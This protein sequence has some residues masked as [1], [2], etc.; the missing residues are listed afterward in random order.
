MSSEQ[1]GG[2]HILQ[3]PDGNVEIRFELKTGLVL[4]VPSENC[5]FYSI[6]Y[7]GREVIEES[8]LGLRFSAAG[9]LSNCFEVVNVRTS[10]HDDEWEPV[11]GERAVIPDC[12]RE[13]TVE[14]RETIPPGRKL[15][16]TFRA[17]NEGAALRYTIP[18]Q[19]GLAELCIIDELTH[20]TFPEGA[21]GYAEYH[22]EGEYEKVPVDEIKPNCEW[23]LTVQCPNGVCL[24][25]TEAN[26]YD[27]PRMQLSPAK[28]YKDDEPRLMTTLNGDAFGK[29]PFTTAWRAFIIGG[30]PGDL[31]ERNHLVSNLNPP[32]AI[33][34]TSWIKPGK[35]IREVTLST[36]GSI[37]CVDFA[38]EH[39]LEHILLD[40]G[41]YG[42]A[43][44]DA[45]DARVVNVK[46]PMT[47]DGLPDHPG[48][49]MPRV[50]EYARSK[51]IGVWLY[52][53]HQA[54]ERQMD[55]L[56]PLYES[57]GAIGV[58]PGFVNV[59]AQGWSKWNCDMIA[60]AAEHH[61]M[62][63][64]HDEYR[65]TGF[66]RT[67]PNLLTQEGIRGQEN[68]PTARHNCTL[69]FVRFPA[70]PADYT[71]SYLFKSIKNRCS[72]QLAL[73]VIF[74]SPA[75][76][77]F[78][79]MKPDQLQDLPELELWR[80]VPTVWDET[81][82]IHGEIGEYV[83][84]AR[85]SGNEWYVGSITS[86]DGRTLDVPLSFLE[87]GVTYAAQIYSD[88]GDDGTRTSIVCEERTAGAAAVI[89]AKMPALG[90]HSMRLVPRDADGE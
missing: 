41:W 15:H 3:S 11:Y 30:H 64:I 34:D 23:P 53:N 46:N 39:G 2:R 37:A 19:D 52:V 26:L 82:C 31:I 7:E 14:L 29:A 9:E 10:E 13:M 81:R 21:A 50:I 35:T 78:W 5:P 87:P 25:L 62:V 54:L 4:Y 89:E 28:W 40:W 84:V 59:G 66:C 70:G 73:P 33:D 12:Y 90:G 60:K 83:T 44:L 85:R 27:Y 76:F 79:Y 55:E 47:G 49:D 18:E 20:F 38:S 80:H 74:Y 88:S 75:Q 77:L 63:D 65:P 72:H 86:D 57:W 6:R 1:T 69:P 43:D 58:K 68:M 36:P 45:A 42:M 56:F 67:Y 22:I 51:G 17:Y 48:L 8:Q 32:C 61:L 16:I 71:P 24:C